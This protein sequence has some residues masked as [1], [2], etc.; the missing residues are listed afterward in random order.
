MSIWQHSDIL[1]RKGVR[2]RPHSDISD[3]KFEILLI[4][5]GMY[6]MSFSVRTVC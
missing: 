2:L 6:E 1:S 5:I 3:A 4:A